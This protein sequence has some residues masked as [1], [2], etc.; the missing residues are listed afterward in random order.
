MKRKDFLKLP[1]WQQ[2]LLPDYLDLLSSI[3]AKIIR[4]SAFLQDATAEAMSFLEGGGSETSSQAST[5]KLPIIEGDQDRLRST[6]RQMVREW[7]AEVSSYFIC[8]FLT[9]YRARLKGNNVM[10]PCWK[11]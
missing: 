10:R 6:I 11:L 2:A 9:A 3:D 5:S 4:N 1:N 7:S 8:L